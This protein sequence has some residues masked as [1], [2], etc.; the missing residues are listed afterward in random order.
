MNSAHTDE[1]QLFGVLLEAA[2]DG[3]VVIDRRGTLRRMNHQGLALFGY[4]ADEII[5]RN[6]SQLMPE[7]HASQHDAYVS[8]YLKTGTKRIIGIGREVLGKRK[9][10]STFVMDLSVGEG[11]VDG[12]HFFIGVMRD[13]TERNALIHELRE[14][15]SEVRGLVENALVATGALDP[16]GRF[17]GWNDSFARALR[18]SDLQGKKLIGFLPTN[19][20][21]DFEQALRRLSESGE[22]E[23][24]HDRRFQVNDEETDETRVGDIYLSPVRDLDAPDE[25]IHR[26]VVQF[27]DRTTEVQAERAALEAQNR[28]AHLNRLG[29]LGEMAAGISH[30]VNQ[31]L[32]AISNY[33]QA[34]RFML[35]APSTDPEALLGVLEKIAAQAER[36]GSVIRR[37]R[38]LAGD[39]TT[40]RETCDL[41]DLIHEVVGLFGSD[42]RFELPRLDVDLGSDLPEVRVDRVQIQQV[43]L[44]L[45]RNALDAMADVPVYDRQLRLECQGEPSHV[46]ISVVDRGHGIIPEIADQ[47]TD[48]FFSTKEHGMGMGLAICAS[49]VSSHAGKL[50]HSANE[51]APGA[52]FHVQLPLPVTSS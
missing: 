8:R 52:T 25:P 5:G 42:A 28:I 48:P 10:G 39:T 38:A 21:R 24:L 41:A 45:L 51:P 16:E 33:A 46:T 20:Q 47:L 6:I 11:E 4:E 30:E 35:R 27:V 18:T 2:V 9:D 14:R 12:E 31:P 1:G 37:M 50:W 40:A 32:G 7:P 23:L 15:E 29:T 43:L 49:I 36:A 17:L 3:I 13:L 22:S 26:L 44:N 34:A 19:Q